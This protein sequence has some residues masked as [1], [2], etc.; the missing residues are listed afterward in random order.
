[1]NAL[2]GWQIVHG[3]K[4]IERGRDC[5]NKGFFN[6]FSDD[7]SYIFSLLFAARALI[8]API[9]RMDCI[10]AQSSLD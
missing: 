5:M 10:S 6:P 4:I 9:A 8:D 7:L 1:L 2:G 3:H